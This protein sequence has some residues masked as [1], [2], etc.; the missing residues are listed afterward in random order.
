[1]AQAREHRYSIS[2]NQASNTLYI[3][4]ITLGSHKSNNVEPL[5]VFRIT[6]MKYSL[7]GILV[8]NDP[9]ESL[10]PYKTDKDIIDLS[11]PIL[12]IEVIAHLI[13]TTKTYISLHNT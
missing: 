10:I 13:M 12:I 4:F 3:E 6:I 9:A 1:M 8:H 2:I 11:P 5:N 7:C